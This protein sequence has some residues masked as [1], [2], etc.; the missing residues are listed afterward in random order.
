[1]AERAQILIRAKDETAN[2]FSSVQRNLSGT[3]GSLRA[4]APAIATAFSVG[5]VLAFAK[6]AIDAADELK[7]M[8]DQTGFTVERLSELRHAANQSDTDIQ[9]LQLG[10]KQFSV[11]LEATA[12]GTG[13]ARLALKALGIE[14]VDQSNGQLRNMDAV[15][16]DV[17][18]KFSKMEDGTTKAALAQRIFGEAGRQLIPLL[19]R[20]KA[21]IAELSAEASRLG[22]VMTSEAAKAA[23]QLNDVLNNL[24]ATGRE[25]QTSMVNHAAPGLDRIGKATK[26]AL[27]DSGP[28][29]AFWVAFGGAVAESLGTVDRGLLNTSEQIRE[30]TKDIEILESKLKSFGDNAGPVRG[31]GTKAG[32]QRDIDAKRKELSDLQ[33]RLEAERDREERLRGRSGKKDSGPKIENDTE[34]KARAKLLEE[35]RKSELAFMDLKDASNQQ[36]FAAQAETMAKMRELQEKEIKDRIDFEAMKRDFDDQQNAAIKETMARREAADAAEKAR[37]DNRVIGLMDNFRTEQGL[38]DQDLAQKSLLRKEWQRREEDQLLERR[39]NRLVDEEEFNRQ[40][41]EIQAR[42]L[43][44]QLKLDKD[45]AKAKL[46]L[47]SQ[48]TQRL[49][50]LVIGAKKGELGAIAGLFSEGVPLMQAGSRKMF[51]IGKAASLAGAVVSTAQAVTN[52]LA[53]QPF[54][55]GLALAALAA[56]KGAIQI[57][58]IRSTQFG[59]GGTVGTGVFSANP[60]TGLPTDNFGAPAPS[61]VQ[62]TAAPL[63]RNINITFTSSNRRYTQEEIRDALIPGLQEAFEAGVKVRFQQ[64]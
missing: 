52:A 63:A 5:G 7:T 40:L 54:P 49:Q 29:M 12:R 25:L 38:I 57:Q 39:A 15:L 32:V 58:A 22:L 62:P 20:G 1:M 42:H 10:L 44:Y 43:G 31:L 27:E 24:S 55:V 21:G 8:A 9:T 6:S 17:A 47:K 60:S 50:N 28:L 45:F 48:E 34:R 14:A 46:G 16:L 59:G 51:E 4:F 35:R 19:N 2:A 3:I 23:D 36:Q 11:N 53:V 64:G 37:F 26:Q 13:E 56:A 41:T 61:P 30:V 18:E 33:A